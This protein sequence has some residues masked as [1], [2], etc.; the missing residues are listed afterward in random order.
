MFSKK[1]IVMTIALAVVSLST[2]GCTDKYKKQIANLTDKNNE[3][4]ATNSNLQA[5]L[6]Q[7][8]SRINNLENQLDAKDLQIEQAKGDRNAALAQLAA[9]KSSEGKAS[10][11]KATTVGDEISVGTDVLFS[12][13]RATLTSAG[14]STL[15]R[16][17]QD[18]KTTYAGYPIRVYGYTDSDPIRKSKKY[19]KDNL[20]LSANRAMAVSRYL[21]QT[22]IS[23]SRVETVAMGDTHPVASNK[24]KTDKKKNRRV[25]IMVVKK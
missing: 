6:A 23:K 24:T 5:G 1:T 25:E 3:L 10:G 22:G 15:S 18:L 4:L 2:V 9:L 16:I 8:E 14:K 7:R 11:W 17:A 19:W 21:I 13:G 12:P 20:D